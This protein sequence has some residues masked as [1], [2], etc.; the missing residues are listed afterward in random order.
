MI[1]AISAMIVLLLSHIGTEVLASEPNANGDGLDARGS[2]ASAGGPEHCVRPSPSKRLT[3]KK[4]K[5]SHKALR[6]YNSYVTAVNAYLVCLANEANAEIDARVA[7]I[8]SA[9]DREQSE[10]LDIVD[11]LARKL[12]VQPLPPK[13]IEVEE[14]PL[15]AVLLGGD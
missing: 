9:H 3:K 13:P 1:R 7:E 12:D 6:D 14:D 8:M 11:S 2:E 10:V 15:D 4:V 5:P